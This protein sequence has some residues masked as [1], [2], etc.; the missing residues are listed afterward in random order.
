MHWHLLF[1]LLIFIRYRKV[2]RFWWIKKNHSNLVV[3]GLTSNQETLQK[4]LFSS[5]CHDYF[6]VSVGICYMK[7]R[8]EAFCITMYLFRYVRTNIRLHGYTCS[9][10]QK[11]TQT[12]P[13]L[14]KHQLIHTHS[15]ADEWRSSDTDFCLY[16]HFPNKILWLIGY[17]SFRRS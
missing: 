13:T 17:V 5:N 1:S 11:Y 8:W 3:I 14:T 12:L 10:I 9:Y 7:T 2:Y 16:G 4:L 15:L 6:I